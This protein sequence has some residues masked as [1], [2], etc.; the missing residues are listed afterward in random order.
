MADSN[1]AMAPQYGNRWGTCSIEVLT[2]P[3]T[4]AAE[5]K[6]FMQDISNL[7]MSLRASDN[8]SLNVRPHWAKQWQGLTFK[9]LPANDYLKNTAYKDQIPVFKSSLQKVALAGGYSLKDCQTMFSNKVF[10][11][12]FEQVF[13]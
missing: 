5:W 2:T 1:I 3:N 12:I 11:D 9:G 8:S 13:I 4:D 7:W 6:A 10:D